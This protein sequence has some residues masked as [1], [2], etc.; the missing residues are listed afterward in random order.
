M[1]VRPHDRLLPLPPFLVEGAQAGWD[2][3]F[4]GLR[5]TGHFLGRDLLTERRAGVL[6]ARERLIDRL[7]RIAG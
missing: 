3:I 7:R 1:Q 5:L 2:D 4:D 6:A